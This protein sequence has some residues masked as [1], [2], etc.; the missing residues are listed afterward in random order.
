M[1][2]DHLIMAADRSSGRNVHIYD[3]KDRVTLLGG[4]IL[5]NGITKSNFYSMVEIFLLFQSSFSIEYEDS[6][7]LERN[8]DPL[9]QGKYYITGKPLTLIL[10]GAIDL[11]SVGFFTVS[12]EPILTRTISL[13]T[14]T[15]LQSFR[16]EVRRRDGRCII[17][18]QEAL[19]IDQD[20]WTGFEV[21]HVFPLAYEGHWVQHNFARWITIPAVNG[22]TI[23]SKQNGL[24]LRADI[25]GLFDNYD[26]SINPD[27]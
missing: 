25:H 11:Y 8:K 15:R 7:I 23:N 9:P 10:I 14:A 1:H 13:S 17:T 6:A 12:N 5:T 24:L 26:L 19:G 16:N 22:E 27:V 18:G 21:A 3:A 2:F 4:L 20:H